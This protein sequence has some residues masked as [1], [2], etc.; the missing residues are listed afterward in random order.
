LFIRNNIEKNYKKKLLEKNK[1]EIKK[2]KRKKNLFL[3]VII[4]IKIC[5][6]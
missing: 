1:K 6:W 2:K 5:H 4:K 3:K